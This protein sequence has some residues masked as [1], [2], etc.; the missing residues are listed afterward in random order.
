MKDE[1]TWCKPRGVDSE[2]MVVSNAVVCIECSDYCSLNTSLDLQLISSLG[3]VD[4]ELRGEHYTIRI[5]AYVVLCERHF[6]LLHQE[7]LTCG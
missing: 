6:Q 5:S 7:T 3:R 4:V 1:G 2:G